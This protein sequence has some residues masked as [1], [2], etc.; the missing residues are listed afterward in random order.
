MHEVDADLIVVGLGAMGAAVALH[1]T[2][3]GLDV[4]GID[5]FA[6]PHGLGSTKAETRITRL[7]VGEGPQYLPFVRRSHEIW[8]DLEDEVGVDLLHECGGVIITEQV[9][10]AG[11]RWEDFVTETARIAAD[12]GIPFET[13]SPDAARERHPWIAVADDQKV[14]FEPTAGLV[15]VERCVEAQL[16]RAAAGGATMRTDEEVTSLTP[17]ETGVVV[18]TTL[19]TYRATNVVLSTGPWIRDLATP[20]HAELITITR[21]VV[22]WFEVDDLDAFT[23]DS[24]PYV[25]WIAE[26]DEDY[27]GLFPMPPGGTPAVKILGEQFLETTDPSTVERT[28]SQAEIDAFY[29]RHVS[30]KFAGVR[31]DCVRAEVCLYANTPDDHFLVDTDPR[32]DRITVMSPCSGHGF[33][34]STALGQ[35]VAQRIASGAN[36]G[37]GFREGSSELDLTPFSAVRLGGSPV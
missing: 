20:A 28:V 3:L 21:Q 19:G 23:T 36:L 33:K 8:R 12:G 15:M 6:P 7:A 10:V 29:D 5:R 26:Q 9:P 35:A 37:G 22:Y 2:R 1:A 11:Q 17:D 18:E 30:P 24:I 32:S 31:R 14:G 34:H 4:L 25:M 13:V 16:E 27:I